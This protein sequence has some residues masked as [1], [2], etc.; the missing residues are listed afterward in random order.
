MRL[1]PARVSP[2]RME[3]EDAIRKPHFAFVLIKKGGIYLF[4]YGIQGREIIGL[5]IARPAWLV[6]KTS[7]DFQRDTGS[8]RDA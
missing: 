6:I 1:F 2:A 4:H 7:A 3:E 5:Q 8:R